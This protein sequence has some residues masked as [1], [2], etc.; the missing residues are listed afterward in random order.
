[1]R[2]SNT[3]ARMR[4][5]NESGKVH[6]TALIVDGI[7]EAIGDKIREARRSRGLT[8]AEL[9]LAADVAVDALSDFER[10]AQRPSPETLARLADI[11]HLSIKS[12]FDAI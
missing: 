10:G 2:Y 3:A 1:M 5:R 9:A 11:L 7:D 6:E 8:S 12:L 4:C